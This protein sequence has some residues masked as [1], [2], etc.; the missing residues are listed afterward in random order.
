MNFRPF[1]SGDVVIGTATSAAPFTLVDDA[2]DP[3]SLSILDRVA[4]YAVTSDADG[5]QIGYGS[6]PLLAVG[7]SGQSF[8]WGVPLPVGEAP[9][10]TTLGSATFVSV[11][12][13]I[14]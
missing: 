8:P 13:E 3:V 1:P 11:I 7:A 4:I 6:T 9:V 10:V 14:I 5:V 2:G 12:C